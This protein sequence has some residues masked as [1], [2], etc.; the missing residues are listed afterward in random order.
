MKRFPDICLNVYLSEEHSEAEYIIVNAGLCSLAE[1]Y[2]AT[3]EGQEAEEYV[4]FGAQLRA[5][6]ETALANLP[7]NLPATADMVIALV[8]GVSTRVL[9]MV[10]YHEI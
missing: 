1:D 5:N 3:V 8:F 4:A 10:R 2:A 9:F 6:L 7:L